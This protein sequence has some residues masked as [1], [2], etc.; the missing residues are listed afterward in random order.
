MEMK[1]I[2]AASGGALINMTPTQAKELISTMAANSQQ[3]GA[4]S[5]PSRRVHEVIHPN[6]QESKI[7]KLLPEKMK[8]SHNPFFSELEKSAHTERVWAA[9]VWF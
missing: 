2:D 5:E 3:F 4:I 6:K 8:K 7:R 1:M 9:R